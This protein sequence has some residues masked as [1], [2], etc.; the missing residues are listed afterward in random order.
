VRKDGKRI[1]VLIAAARL[2][3]DGERAVA[4]VLPLNQVKKSDRL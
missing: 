2:E 1:R 3:K 4:F